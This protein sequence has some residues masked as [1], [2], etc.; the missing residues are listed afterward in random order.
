MSSY[1]PTASS[2]IHD[3]FLRFLIHSFPNAGYP[4]STGKDW[5]LPS[6]ATTNSCTTPP[7]SRHSALVLRVVRGRAWP[8]WKCECWFASSC[9]D[10]IYDFRLATNRHNM[11]RKSRT[12]SSCSKENYLSS[13]VHAT[14]V[15]SI[16]HHFNHLIYIPYISCSHN[17]KVATGFNRYIWVHSIAKR[18]QESSPNLT[19][20][21]SGTKVLN[22][23]CD[24]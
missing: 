11:L 6:S 9:K 10:M 16:S 7:R 23:K 22:C 12:S 24:G 20:T 4:L 18:I 14:S 21:L 3:T 5:S 19:L 17:S 13:S 15:S 1:P 2:E 8:G